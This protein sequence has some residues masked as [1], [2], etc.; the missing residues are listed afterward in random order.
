MIICAIYGC[1]THEY[2][3][4]LEAGNNQNTNTVRYLDDTDCTEKSQYC[5][6]GSRN[7]IREMCIDEGF[8]ED[9]PVNKVIYSRRIEEKVEGYMKLLTPRTLTRY[10]EDENG[11]VTSTEETLEEEK[12]VLVVGQCIGSEYIT[13]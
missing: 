9:R 4:G 2:P 8:V 5:G 6:E 13:E 11:I 7:R 3:H 10:H 1:S 12:S